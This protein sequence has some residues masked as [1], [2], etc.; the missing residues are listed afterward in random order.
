MDAP[1]DHPSFAALREALEQVRTK[2][3]ANQ[4]D[5]A[6]QVEQ[7]E[8]AVHSMAADTT[9]E[10]EQAQNLAHQAQETLVAFEAHLAETSADGDGD[11]Q[12]I[13]EVEDQLDEA[14]ERLSSMESRFAEAQQELSDQSAAAAAARD[15][16]AKLE[17]ELKE[18]RGAETERADTAEQSLATCTA[19][20]DQALANLSEAKKLQT[21]LE[22]RVEAGEATLH[23]GQEELAAL[24]Q[25][26]AGLQQELEASQN[27]AQEATAELNQ[28]REELV[29]AKAAAGDASELDAARAAAATAEA[30]AKAARAEA[31]DDLERTREALSARE[32]ELAELNEKLAAAPVPED[33]EAARQALQEE[34]V[35]SQTLEQRLEDETAGGTKA[36]L[37]T[38]LA[39]ALRDA[40]EAREELRRLRAAAALQGEA[41]MADPAPASAPVPV[42]EPVA[43]AEEPEWP[44]DPME[45][46]RAAAKRLSGSS[47]RTIGTILVDA[48]I[49]SEEQ[50]E[51]AL[52]AQKA[53]PQNHLGQILVD[54]GYVSESAV[55]LALACQSEVDFVDLNEDTVDPQAATLITERLA[56]KHTCIPVQASDSTLVLAMANPMDLVAIEDVERASSRKVEIVVA[57]RG[58]ILDAIERFYWEPE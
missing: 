26:A 37:A 54:R 48:E 41:P 15:Q 50:I 42:P 18:G 13:A 57:T 51:D 34:R 17:R 19:E 6:N 52:Q 21:D 32:A 33:L 5:F 2:L 27:A 28:L 49:V 44:A 47:R 4:M 14:R 43:A 23:A 22:A 9:A 29:E 1:H 12:R 3:V 7:L 58:D 35:K 8:K 24:R 25:E 30:E 36:V 55:G 45:R 20:R 56:Q 10:R 40:E 46:I 39:D 38:Q 53:N 31:Q 16:V 11:K